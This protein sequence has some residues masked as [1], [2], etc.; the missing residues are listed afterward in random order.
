MLWRQ[1]ST[2]AARSTRRRPSQVKDGLR[3]TQ[4][5]PGARTHRVIWPHAARGGDPARRGDNAAA[6]LWSI[7]PRS[8]S[9][10]SSRGQHHPAVRV[11][12]VVP[13]STPSRGPSRGQCARGRIRP[14]KGWIGGGRTTRWNRVGARGRSDRE[15]IPARDQDPGADVELAAVD[16]QAG[17]DV[18]AEA[19]ARTVRVG[20]D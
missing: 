12:A 3:P 13:R 2:T 9:R 4:L 6:T 5:Q 11:A 14:S 20:M 7:I 18:P 1:C 17:L 16:E 19:R 15:G 10:P 8:E